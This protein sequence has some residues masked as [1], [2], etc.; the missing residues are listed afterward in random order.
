LDPVATVLGRRIR[1]LRAHKSWTQAE[2]AEK[3]YSNKT[4]ISDIEQGHQVPSSAQI[5]RFETA[6]DADGVLRE[7][8]ALLNIGIQEST[9]VADVEQEALTISLWESRQVSGLLQT[10]RYMHAN[11][12]TNVPAERLER[13]IAI[14]TARQKVLA[15]L[16][17]GWFVL[18]EAVLHRVYGGPD[19]M[20]EQLAHLEE[21]AS[22]PNLAIQVMPYTSTRHPGSDGP[23]AI[24]E[25][26]DKPG[27][28]VTEGPR[29]GRMSD[30]RAEVARA[31]HDMNLIRAAA[32]PPHES[33]DFIKKIRETSYEQLA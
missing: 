20:R 13:E 22:R 18:D 10:P 14:R 21:V 31:A 12:S 1:R 16:V 5:E 9:V 27:I 32:L 23:L 4:T 8:Y 7:L 24:I 15:R 25:Y 26:S 2:L 28:W 29:S 33:V 11:M 30:D 17:A 6:L 19:V 3:A